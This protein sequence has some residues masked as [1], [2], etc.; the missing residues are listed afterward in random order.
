PTWRP[1]VRPARR[2]PPFPRLPPPRARWLVPPLRPPPAARRPAVPRA[3]L[4]S[5]GKIPARLSSAVVRPGRPLGLAEPAEPPQ[6]RLPL[7][8]RRPSARLS[9]TPGPSARRAAG[10]RFWQVRLA[11]QRASFGWWPRLT[12]FPSRRPARRSG[13]FGYARRSPWPSPVIRRRPDHQRASP[14][15]LW[16]A[17]LPAVASGGRRRASL[18]PR[19]RLSIPHRIF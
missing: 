18:R 9:P 5:A 17:R 4:P 13:R 14:L 7:S 2:A 10:H 19:L 8:P 1:R 6:S 16:R 12:A 3:S 15:L 11:D